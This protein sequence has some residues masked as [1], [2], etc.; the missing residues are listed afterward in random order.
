MYSLQFGLTLAAVTAVS[1]YPL[2]LG[3][4]GFPLSHMEAVADSAIPRIPAAWL[5]GDPADSLYRA[6]RESLSRRDFRTAATLFGQIPGRFPRSGYAGDALYWQAFALYRLGGD[7]DLQKAREVLRKQ[8]DRYP[9]TATHGDAAALESRILGEL[10]R[11]GDSEAAAEI[12]VL[13]R[14]NAELEQTNVILKAATSFFV[15]ESDP[16]NCR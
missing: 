9:R 10:A 2:T 1:G 7:K 11:R 8:R 12:P 4:A 5:Q 16:R 15:R 14:R 6:A 13:R 3:D